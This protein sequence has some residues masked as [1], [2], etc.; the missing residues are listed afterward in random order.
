[1]WTSI[2]ALLDR[3]PELWT[4]VVTLAWVAV[5]SVFCSLYDRFSPHTD[6]EWKA[7]LERHP[8]WNGVVALFKTM[9]FNIPGGLRALRVILTRKPP[10][11]LAKPPTSLDDAKALLRDAGFAVMRVG[12]A[13]PMT[14]SYAPDA[15]PLPPAGAP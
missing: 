4:L 9:G 10:A 6:P 13:V 2:L 14:V 12:D 11:A 5:S 8:V 1:M 3:F 15:A 7:A